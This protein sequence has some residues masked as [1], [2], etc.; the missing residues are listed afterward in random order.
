[1]RGGHAQRG[2]HEFIGFADE[3]H[4]G[5]L[6]AVVDHLDEV[7]AAIG[8]DVGAARLAVDLRGD[9]SSIGPTASYDLPDR[10]A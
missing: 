6:D 8:A 9:L 10:R 2:A 1:M 7:A 4:V 3:L 5:V